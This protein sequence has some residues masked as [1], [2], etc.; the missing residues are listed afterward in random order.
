MM[1]TNYNWEFVVKIDNHENA[2]SMLTSDQKS[3]LDVGKQKK[4]EI[5]TAQQMNLRV[6]LHIDYFHGSHHS[7]WKQIDLNYRGKRGRKPQDFLM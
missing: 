3:K 2:S 5:R 4:P 6:F 7:I 1:T